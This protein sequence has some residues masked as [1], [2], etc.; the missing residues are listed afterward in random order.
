MSRNNRA[1]PI[2]VLAVTVVSLMTRGVV[3]TVFSTVHGYAAVAEVYIAAWERAQRA[4]GDTKVIARHAQRAAADLR[5]FAMVFPIGQPAA[6]RLTGEAHWLASRLGPAED[7]WQKALLYARELKMPY[8]EALAHAAIARHSA[9]SE[10]RR[11]HQ[12]AAFALF[13]KLGCERDAR[14]VEALMI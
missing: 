11:E 12:R 2:L 10:V 9:N 14:Q 7:A 8:E 3:S 4:G 13:I 5:T 1:A 6:Q